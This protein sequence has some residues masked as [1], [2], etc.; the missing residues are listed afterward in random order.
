MASTGPAIRIRSGI[1]NQQL[2]GNPAAGCN[3]WE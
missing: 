3:I 2:I 1:G